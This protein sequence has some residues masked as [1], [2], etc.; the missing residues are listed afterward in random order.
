MEFSTEISTNKAAQ[1]RRERERLSNGKIEIEVEKT[2]R[3]R[4]NKTTTLSPVNS[5]EAMDAIP[6]ELH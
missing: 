1:A 2:M 4:T 3:A 5:E 6:E